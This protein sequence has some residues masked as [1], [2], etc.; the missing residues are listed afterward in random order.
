MLDA[1]FRWNVCFEKFSP[2]Y[3]RGVTEMQGKQ[4]G[5]EK[6]L[7]CSSYTA[8]GRNSTFPTFH[9]IHCCKQMQGNKW[10]TSIKW[11]R[12]G[13]LTS[14]NFLHLFCIAKNRKWL[15]FL[16]KRIG[17]KRKW[18]SGFIRIYR[19]RRLLRCHKIFFISVLYQEKIVQFSALTL[20]M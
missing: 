3:D 14:N 20:F 9:Y 8:C 15:L 5:Y 6:T 19:F 17:E 18:K 2:K 11:K 1:I 7:D 12:N 16:H 13:N 10:V 4:S